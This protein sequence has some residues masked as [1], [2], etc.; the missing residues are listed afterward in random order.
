MIELDLLDVGE[1]MS[2][3]GFLDGQLLV[4]MPGMPDPRF[5][6]VR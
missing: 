1:D 6:P 5:A 4:A 3:R 2:S